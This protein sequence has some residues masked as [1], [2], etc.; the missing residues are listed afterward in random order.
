[1]GIFD[2]RA[3]A[4]ITPRGN[5]KIMVKTATISVKAGNLTATFTVTVE[6]HHEEEETHDENEG[7]T[8]VTDDVDIECVVGDCG[9]RYQISGLSDLPEAG[10][11]LYAFRDASKA[12]SVRSPLHPAANRATRTA[13]NKL[14][15]T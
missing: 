8:D 9:I 2:V 14:A 10:D 7:F 6:E 15:A 1:M 13:T 4:S 5:E 11:R 3:S 12:R